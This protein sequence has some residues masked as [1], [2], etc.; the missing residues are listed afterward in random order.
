MK[1]NFPYSEMIKVG[2]IGEFI[3]YNSIWYPENLLVFLRKTA[4]LNNNL[5]AYENLE[6]LREIPNIKKK[7]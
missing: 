1:L 2:E 4:L 3:A 7:N 5:S 6:R